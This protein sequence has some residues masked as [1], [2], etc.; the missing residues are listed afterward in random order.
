MLA[1]RQANQNETIE[2]E[3]ESEVSWNQVNIKNYVPNKIK[4][5]LETT[6]ESQETHTVRKAVVLEH[7]KRNQGFEIEF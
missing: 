5:L 2:L 4:Q 6:S 7:N 3:P 1:V